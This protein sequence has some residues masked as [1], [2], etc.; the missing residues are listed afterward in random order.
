MLIVSGIPGAS[1]FISMSYHQHRDI[2]LDQGSDLRSSLPHSG[3]FTSPTQTK[4]DAQVALIQLLLSRSGLSKVSATTQLRVLDVGCGLGGTTRYLAQECGFDVTG[5]TISSEQVKMA[6]NLSRTAAGL[7]SGT[8]TT[9][10]D[11]DELEI[12]KLGA[13]S[14]RF[15]QMDAETMGERFDSERFD[16][17]WICEALSHFPDK[18]LFFRNAAKVLVP[19]GRLVMADWFRSTEVAVDSQVFNDEIKPIEDGML[20]PPLDTMRGYTDLAKAAG[21]EVRPELLADEEGS[22]QGQGWKDISQEVAKTWWVETCLRFSISLGNDDLVTQGH[23]SRSHCQSFPLGIRLY[24]RPRLCGLPQSFPSDAQGF[25]QRQLP[26]WCRGILE[27][28]VTR[29]RQ[30]TDTYI[31]AWRELVDSL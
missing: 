9:S 22:S 6:Y 14:V 13:G 5:V 24:P 17:V 4:E 3:Y 1:T 18:A 23:L 31:E 8:P 7:S 15:I 26:L 19:G 11:G 28:A 21:L 16:V 25:R 30:M 2:H 29:L 27:I 12:V 20:L 10:L